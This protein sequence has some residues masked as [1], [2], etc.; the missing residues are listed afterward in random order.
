MYVRV[1]LLGVMLLLVI[2]SARDLSLSQAR[3]AREE[4]Y[5]RKAIEAIEAMHCLNHNNLLIKL[6]LHPE[7]IPDK[8]E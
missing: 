7:I 3:N 8:C 2:Y 5:F 1:L 4:A 6:L